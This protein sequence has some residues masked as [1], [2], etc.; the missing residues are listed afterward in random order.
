MSAI[1]LSDF[2]SMIQ[3]I[4]QRCRLFAGDNRAGLINLRLAEQGT[5]IGDPSLF[6]FV[7]RIAPA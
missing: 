5:G 6:Q 4:V 3:Q 2:F 7:L 1:I